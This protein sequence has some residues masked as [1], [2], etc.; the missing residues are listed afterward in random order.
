MFAH[1]VDYV[2]LTGKL[3]TAAFTTTGARSST[4]RAPDLLLHHG[5]GRPAGKQVLVL[6]NKG[7]DAAA[8]SAAA[9]SLF[10]QPAA[11]ATLPVCDVQEGP[12]PGAAGGGHKVWKRS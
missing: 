4:P 9:P 7:A 11:G 2:Y 1:E 12:G 10:K 8:I 5:E 3:T 6:F